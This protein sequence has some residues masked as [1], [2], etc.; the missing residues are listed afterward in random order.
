MPIEW[1]DNTTGEV[2]DDGNLYVGFEML[3]G[4]MVAAKRHDGQWDIPVELTDSEFK[5]VEDAAK[6]SGI[7]V[8]EFFNQ[9]VQ[10]MLDSK[11]FPD[12]G[13]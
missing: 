9:V 8:Q 5:M 7:S 3:D 4:K 11:S 6:L 1:M 2:D 10:E 13:K 12:D